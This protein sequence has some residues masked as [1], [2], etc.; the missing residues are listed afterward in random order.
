[1]L[2]PIFFLPE[3]GDAAAF[4]EAAPEPSE[5]PAASKRKIEA[6]R[7]KELDGCDYK[8]LSGF[9][10]AESPF[11]TLAAFLLACSVSISAI[12]R[13]RCLLIASSYRRSLSRSL[14]EGRRR[15]SFVRKNK[16]SVAGLMV[17]STGTTAEKPKRSEE[18]GFV[19][20]QRLAAF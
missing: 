18:E 8:T 7:R 16:V 4:S 13:S 9:V 3:R 12:A 14:F 1:M 19:S 5:T 20:C 2:R 10:F 17:T 15:S 11:A 6:N